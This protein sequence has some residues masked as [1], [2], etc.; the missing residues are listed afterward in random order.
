MFLNNVSNDNINN[1]KNNINN[2]KHFRTTG[3]D[4]KIWRFDNN[5]DQMQIITSTVILYN[6]YIEIQVQTALIQYY[7]TSY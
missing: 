2:D 4:A 6:F 3:S 5:L 1:D 7:N